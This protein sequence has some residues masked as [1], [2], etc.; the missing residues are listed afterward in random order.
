MR[1]LR[2]L[3]EQPVSREAAA[4]WPYQAAQMLQGGKSGPQQVE[5][6]IESFAACFVNCVW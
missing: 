2:W 3:H 6:A 4:V 1:D 5:T